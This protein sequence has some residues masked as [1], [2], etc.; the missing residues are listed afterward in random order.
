MKRRPSA[1]LLVIAPDDRILLFKTDDLP[2]DPAAK[3]AS[4]WFLPGGALDP[5][6]TFEEAARRELWEETGIEGAKIGPCVWTR[7]VVLRFEDVG[8]ALAVEHYFPVRVGETALEFSNM[9]ELEVAVIT[10]HRWWSAAELRQTTD[11]IFPEALGTML[12]PILQGDYP[13]PPLVIE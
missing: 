1:R 6:E 3:I 2:L 13:V 5:G 4:Y 10:A 12:E 11:T 8:E 9:T 7:E